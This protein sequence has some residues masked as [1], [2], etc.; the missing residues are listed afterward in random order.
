MKS[1]PTNN[2]GGFPG[3]ASGKEPPCQYRKC[4]R[5][6]FKNRGN[7]L[8]YSCPFQGSC[9]EN[10]MDRGAWR[11]TVLRVAKSRT[12]LK[13]RSMQHVVTLSPARNS[14]FPHTRG[15]ALSGEHQRL[16][17]M[18]CPLK[19]C[20]DSNQASQGYETRGLGTPG[21]N[22]SNAGAASAQQTKLL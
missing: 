5:W 3:G 15:N 12:R 20:G 17:Y 1:P 6:G 13:Q 21:A 22:L 16:P 11:A 10:P 4:K 14:G 19:Q 9:L 18:K 7:G 2:N 8:Q